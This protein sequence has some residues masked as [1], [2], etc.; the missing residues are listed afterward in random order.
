M[1]ERGVGMWC[2][3]VRNDRVGCGKQRFVADGVCAGGEGGGGGGEVRVSLSKDC[4]D[5]VSG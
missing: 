3:V 2:C 5:Y 4:N 1:A